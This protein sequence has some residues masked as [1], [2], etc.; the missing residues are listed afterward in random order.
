MK[1]T[2]PT[3][4]GTR[5]H[6]AAAQEAPRAALLAPVVHAPTPFP[7][8]PALGRRRR[9]HTQLQQIEHRCE[10]QIPSPA[11]KDGMGAGVSA[12][13]AVFFTYI[14]TARGREPLR[15]AGSN[16]GGCSQSVCMTGGQHE[17]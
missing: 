3:P 4:R 7:L 16:G 1:K 11:A 9:R 10:M 15:E 17:P 5:R 13:A 8:L 6:R 12:G 14:A 2:P